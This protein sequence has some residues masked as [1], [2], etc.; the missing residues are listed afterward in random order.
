MNWQ[1]YQ[2]APQPYIKFD[3][4]DIS[5]VIQVNDF[6]NAFCQIV[7]AKNNTD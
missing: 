1:Y 3:V 4:V 6:G 5:C 2:F 7:N